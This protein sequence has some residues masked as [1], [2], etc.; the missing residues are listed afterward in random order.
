MKTQASIARAR[1]AWT[2]SDESVQFSSSCVCCVVLAVCSPIVSE[3]LGGH[4]ELAE[5]VDRLSGQSD[6]RSNSG[7][8]G[9]ITNDILKRADAY[10]HGVLFALAPFISSPVYW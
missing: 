5:I 1:S 7:F 10:R 8:M 3:L 9:M 6:V 2:R 4:T